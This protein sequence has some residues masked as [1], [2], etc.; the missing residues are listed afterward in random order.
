MASANVNWNRSDAMPDTMKLS[1]TKRALLEKYLSGAFPQAAADTHTITRLAS[2]DRAPLSFGQQQI[3]LLAQLMPSMPV[4]NECVT[5]HLPGPL[6]VAML[7]QSL[8]EFIRRHEAW[9]TSFP[10]VDGQPVQVIHPPSPLPLRVADLRHLPEAEREAEALRLATEDARILFDLAHGPLLRATLIRLCDEEHRLFLT[11]HHIIFDG[12]GIYQVFLP[13]LRTLYEAFL[14]G[15]P[16]PLADLPIQYADY[17]NWQRQ[18]L[19]GETLARQMAYWKQRLQ[20]APDALELPTDRLRPPDQTYRGSMHPFALSR[21]LTDDLVALSRQEG[22]TL[23]TTLVAAFKTLLYRYTGQ[24]DLV[25]GTATAGRKLPEVQRLMGFFLNTLLLRTDLS[26]NPTFRELLGRVREVILEAVAHE[27]VP[28]EYLVKELQPR[29][30]LSQNPLFQVLLTLEPPLPVLPSG[31]TLTQMDVTVGT[32]KLDLSLE[33][34]ARPESLIGRFEYNTDLFDAATIAQMVGHWQTLLKAIVTDPTQ[35]VAEL[36]LLTEGERQQLLV[37]W[38]ATRA[39]YSEERCVHQLFEEQVERTPDV[40][41]VIYEDAHLTY[42]ELNTRANQLAHQLHQLGVGPQV[43]VGICVERSL[44]MVVGLLGILKA[45][46]AYVPL[47]P[48][49]PHERIAFML[50]DAQVPV[51]VTQQHL[52]KH[53]P[54]QQAKVVCLDADASV[55]AQRASTNPALVVSADNLAYVIYTSGST[56]RPKGVQVLHRAVVNFL[57]SMLQQPGLSAEDTLLAVT[58]LSFDIAALELFLPLIVGAHLVVASREV[59]ADGVA[60]AELLALSGATVMQATPVT[61]RLLLAA[62]WSGKRQLKILC[63]GE[64]L[65]KELA[66]QLLPKAASLWNLYG[67]TETTIWSTVCK[68]EPEDELISI[69]RPIA[70]TQIYLL[71]QHLQPV[72]V[73]VP[74]ELYI[75]GAG[76]ARG[77]LNRPEL[78]AE[79]F[80]RHPFSDEPSARLYRTGDL[81]RYRADG[82]IECLGRLD[83]Q[84]KLR[85]FRIELGEIEAVLGHH[86]A[87]RQAVVVAR[88]DLPGEKRLVA[89]VVLAKEQ[90]TS[91]SDLQSHV[92]KQLPTYMVPSAFVLLETL[93]LT[94]NGKIDRRAL[95]D[96][97]PTTIAREEPYVAPTLKVH[98]QLVRI[99]EELLGVRPIGI[100]DNFFELGGHSLL[101][102]RMVNRIEQVCGKKLPLATLFAGATIEYLANAL[103]QGE[104]TGSRAPLIVVQRGEC[105]RPFFYLHGDWVYGAYYCLKLAHELGPDQPFYVLEPYRFDGLQVPPTF[106]AM[107]AAHIESM[108]AV[109]PEGPYLLGGFCGGGVVAFEMARQLRAAGQAVDLLVLI[110]PGVAP[111][112]LKA[113]GGLIRRLGTLICLG[114]DKQLDWFLLLRHM[115]RL[116]R[117]PEY[118]NSRH[119]SLIPAIEA[120]RQDGDG[121]YAWVASNYVPRQYPGKVTLLWVSG[122]S[123]RRVAWSKL[124]EAEARVKEVEVHFIVGTHETC[125]T[126]HL[127]DLARHL[128]ASLVRVQAVVLSER[129]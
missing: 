38:N 60:L 12:V 52:V 111:L 94:P 26:G 17:A 86:P 39:A 121:I 126:D 115:Y 43:L 51:L 2:R 70:N 49:Y 42:Q 89:Y 99:W 85:G 106:E 117:H 101:A 84:V 63:G 93:P 109:Q 112:S 19:Q 68:I 33:L 28:F 14:A 62:G 47:D 88:E 67:P 96:P 127:S 5:I 97:S 69:G 82:T 114:P 37:G 107:A 44:E 65:P 74:G 71:D 76:L 122:E 15:Q 18:G 102:A 27:D 54:A 55:L 20:G 9:R 7:E 31:W 61:W 11:L 1:E 95:P 59:V 100:Q 73:G 45:G 80:I 77:Y 90:A 83:H 125:R 110:E 57:L 35:R 50:A 103:V 104:D 34:D 64:S 81:A 124:A 41:A 22:V 48:T 92:M 78:T 98:H 53:L 10:V 29:R 128:K 120:L 66:E 75:G 105:K 116:L 108:R 123:F 4:Y 36:P 79:R 113:V 3:W 72:P 87:V 16:S 21:H 13:E 25:I 58:T 30:N 91:V 56:G 46:G 119:F 40:V 129:A 6:N 32:S 8:N 118:R 24:D 23:Y